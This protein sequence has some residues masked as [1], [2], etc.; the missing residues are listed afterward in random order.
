MP[1][2]NWLSTAEMRLWRSFLAASISVIQNIEADLKEQAGLSLDDYEVLVHLSEAPNSRLRMTDLSDRLN[3]SRSR[4]SQRIDRMAK[5]G[6]VARQDSPTDRRS[7]Y[8]VLTKMGRSA[9]AKA[10]PDHLVSVREN[11]V[12]HIPQDEIESMADVLELLATKAKSQ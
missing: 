4:L 7:T 5:R 2:P 12:D 11:V 6:L 3:S 9:I 10:A 1:Q 8:A